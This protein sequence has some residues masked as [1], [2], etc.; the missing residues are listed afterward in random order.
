MN[1]HFPKSEVRMDL[2]RIFLTPPNTRRE[3]FSLMAMMV[4]LFMVFFRPLMFTEIEP[5]RALVL[6]S[7]PTL[8]I[9]WAWMVFLRALFRKPDFCKRKTQ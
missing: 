3:R 8:S 7:L 1:D 2:A 4:I 5:L 9:S 6:A